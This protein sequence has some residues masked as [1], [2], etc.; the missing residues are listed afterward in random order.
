MS[1]FNSNNN[2]NG[3]SSPPGDENPILTAY[4]QFVRD[5]PLVTRYILSGLGACYILS[6]FGDLSYALGT[7]PYF[8]FHPRWEVYRI[9]LSPFICQSILSLI[10]ATLSFLDMG[11]RLEHSL[12]STAFGY[13]L[14]L[15]G[16]CTNILFVCIS[17][18]VYFAKYPDG[19][20]SLLWNSEGIWILIF[21]MIATDCSTATLTGG[22]TNRR[23]FFITV[24]T[25]YFPL[26]LYALFVVFGGVG[27]GELLAIGIGSAY[28][29]GYCH[30]YLKVS[31][32]RCQQWEDS[33]LLNFTQ[34]PGWITGHAA[35]G[36]SAWSEEYNTNNTNSFRF[37]SSA[38]SSTMNTMSSGLPTTTT[39][40]SSN[41]N[42]STTTTPA[43]TGDG[44]ALGRSPSSS[45]QRP[46]QSSEVRAAMLEAAEKRATSSGDVVDSGV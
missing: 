16:I 33:I 42:I 24:P 32:V 43:F 46:T 18:A 5:T 10:F 17:Y 1:L 11:K 35:M 36:R 9:L 3:S 38:P 14:L 28:G 2:N 44:Y 45:R 21:A 30:R 8:C 4:D 7:I 27:M 22:D 34:R 26:A 37:F 19:V 31:T 6:W 15:M 29:Y 39:P 20:D 25:K 41:D 12:G 23:L 40:A 13:Y